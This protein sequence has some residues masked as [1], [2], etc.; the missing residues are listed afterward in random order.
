[1]Y[2][3]L[4][5]APRSGRTTPNSGRNSR[6]RGSRAGGSR[7]VQDFQEPDAATGDATSVDNIMETF[8]GMLREVVTHF[9]NEGGRTMVRKSAPTFEGQMLRFWERVYREFVIPE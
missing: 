7:S 1:M 5:N 3:S 4:A 9:K 8:G 6:S 2:Y